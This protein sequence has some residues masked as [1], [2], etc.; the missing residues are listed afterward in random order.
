MLANCVRIQCIHRIIIVF[1]LPRNPVNTLTGIDIVVFNQVI[2]TV[3]LGKIF[4]ATATTFL[5]LNL[6]SLIDRVV[7]P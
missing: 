4:I 6:S 7:P 2:L 5:G 3:Y 1:P